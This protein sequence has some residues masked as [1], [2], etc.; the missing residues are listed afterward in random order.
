MTNIKQKNLYDVFNTLQVGDVLL[1][2][3]KFGLFSL[4]IN[5]T[6]YLLYKLK[7]LAVIILQSVNADITLAPFF[8]VDH[9]ARIGDIRKA[10]D[11]TVVSFFIYETVAINKQCK[12]FSFKRWRGGTIKTRIASKQDL[13]K[14]HK[15][16]TIY[17][18]QLNQP[19]TKM[20]ENAMF[21]DLEKQVDKT[22]QG[23]TKYTWKY[24]F[25]SPFDIFLSAKKRPNKDTITHINYCQMLIQKNNIA[26]GLESDFTHPQEILQS[27]LQEISKPFYKKDIFQII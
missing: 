27:P 8:R 14:H 26:A 2:H 9:I 15:Y 11:G 17:L 25:L 13:Q 5:G 24:V 22:K 1:T 23:L 3:A 10:K 20:Q 18:K 7:C 19:L 16:K 6:D 12:F 4:V 21:Q